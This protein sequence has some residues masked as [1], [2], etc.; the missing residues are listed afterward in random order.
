MTLEQFKLNM[1]HQVQA[2]SGREQDSAIAMRNEWQHYVR[3]LN[4]WRR[5]VG[6][7]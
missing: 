2:P 1:L 7:K 5:W 3:A 4:A 6:R